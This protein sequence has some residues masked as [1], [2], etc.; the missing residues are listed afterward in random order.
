MAY[1]TQQDLVVRFGQRELVELTDRADPPT[2]EIDAAIVATALGE[3]AGVVD[4]HIARRY[5]LPLAGVPPILTD[6]ACD[7]ARYRLFEHRVTEAVQARYDAAL[8]TLGAIADGALRLTVGGA[9]LAQHPAVLAAAQ[10]QIFDRN[11]MRGY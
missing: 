10:D 9:E 4:G 7:I 11:K 2:G 1:A 8:R 3:A 6:L 5:P